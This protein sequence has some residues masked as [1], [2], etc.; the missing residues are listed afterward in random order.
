M[1]DFSPSIEAAQKALGSAI[2]IETK[3]HPA[4]AKGVALS[5][6]EVAARVKKGRNDPRVR[7]WAI[8]AIKEANAGGPHR[9]P[10]KAQAILTALKKA[11]VYVQDPLNTEFIQAAHETLCLDD[12]GLCFKGGD[13]DDLTVAYGSAVLSVG[14]PFKVIGQAF[15]GGT[16]PTHVMGAVQDTDTKEWLRVDP[17]TDKA[18][19]D[20]VMATEEWWIDPLDEKDGTTKRIAGTGDFVGV[21]SIPSG[22]LGDV[23]EST[24]NIIVQQLQAALYG[25]QTSGNNLAASLDQVAQITKVAGFDP[26]PAYNIV[27]ISDF[28]QTGI[29]TLSMN[30]IAQSILS[31]VQF[32]ESVAQDGL[33][34]ARTIYLDASNNVL[35]SSIAS[36]AFSWNPYAV[37]GDV[38]IAIYN[39]AGSLIQGITAKVGEFMTP[40]E[41]EAQVPAAS[42]N[43]VQGVGVI[44]VLA[45]V[46]IGALVVIDAVAVYAIMSKLADMVTAVAREKSFQTVIAYY[47]SCVA[48]GKCTAAEADA[49]ILQQRQ[50][51]NEAARDNAKDNPFGSTLDAVAGVLKWVAIGGLVIVGG[52]VAMPVLR[53]LSESAA[54]AMRGKRLAKETA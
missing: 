1:S 15:K 16:V 54:G 29:W 7:A 30:N 41:V 24:Q 11:T 2:P 46:G 49:A 25:L 20:Y 12:K 23:P 50:L 17:S 26:E 18:V 21:G 39:A 10:E 44:P 47:Q 32:L 33:N 22:M 53:E 3:D 28:P 38:I 34:G 42:T 31:Q 51:I 14:I 19:G 9:V 45:W 35:I 4:G 36:D 40:A 8:R 48:S 6:D 27:G 5:L 37:A 52:Y 43:T 13:C